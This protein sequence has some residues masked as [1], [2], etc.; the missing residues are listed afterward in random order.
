MNRIGIF[1]KVDRPEARE[2]VPRL[3]EWLIAR[4]RQVLL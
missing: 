2:V 4:G 1:A 3:V